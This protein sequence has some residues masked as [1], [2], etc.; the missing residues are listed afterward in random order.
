MLDN[1][2]GS[3]LSESEVVER[4]QAKRTG[5][6]QESAPIESTDLTE[7]QDET[8]EE[9]AELSDSNEDYEE[10]DQD[11][12]EAV[13]TYRIKASGEELDVT[14]DQLVENFEKG[15][16][17]Y[18]KTSK[19]AEE[20]K[21]FE[22][23]I[24][25]VKQEA[26][27]ERQKFQA[28]TSQLSELVKTTEQSIN[29]EELRDTDPSE[30]LRQKELQEGRVKALSEAQETFKVE[31]AK[32]RQ[33]ALNSESQ[34]LLTVIGDEWKDPEVKQKDIEGMY[35]YVYSKGFTQEDAAQ[36]LDHRAWVMIRDAMKWQALQKSGE[37]VKKQIKTVPKT[38]KSKKVTTRPDKEADKARK[39][40]RESGGKSQDDVVALLKAKRNR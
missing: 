13:E 23:E 3:S 18:K 38:V 19:L 32:K 2:S 6:D 22:A 24:A 8:V 31:Q 4:M 39:R 35:E 25:S 28:V 7:E 17:Y 5:E 29:W 9:E 11:E 14:F 30:Y 37:T 20:R 16:D 12:E 10:S 15:Q 1:L 33:E 21:T 27:A 34:K 36:I 40:L 26:E